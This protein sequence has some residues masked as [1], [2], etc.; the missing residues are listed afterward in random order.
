M[1]TLTLANFWS[2][3]FFLMMMLIGIDSV[4]GQFDFFIAY[5]WDMFPELRKRYKKQTVVLVIAMFF[6]SCGLL[7][8][9]NN[10][11]WYFNLFSKNVGSFSIVFVMVSEMCVVTQYFGFEKLDAVMFHYTGETVPFYMKI[12]V[13]YVSI[14]LMSLVVIS[15]LYTE[16]KGS[17]DPE[18]TQPI[19]RLLIAIPIVATLLGA[20][21]K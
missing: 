20:C 13:K 16:L 5:C 2:V 9:T 4:F 1:S 10:G 21:L 18:W 19:A 14:P 17:R 15:G 11:W 8:V 7:F 6:C 3:M 12:C